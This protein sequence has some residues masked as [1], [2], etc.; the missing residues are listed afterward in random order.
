ME[1]HLHGQ[2]RET[3]RIAEWGNVPVLPVG[4]LSVENLMADF[5][6]RNPSFYSTFNSRHSHS[7]RW[8]Y[9]ALFRKCSC[10][11][12]RQT[13]NERIDTTAALHRGGPADTDNDFDAVW[14]ANWRGLYDVKLLYICRSVCQSGCILCARLYVWQCDIDCVM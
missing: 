13:D 5:L 6:N 4:L 2:P 11:T 8:F 1:R 9:L 7:W 14:V 3:P 12:H 10:V